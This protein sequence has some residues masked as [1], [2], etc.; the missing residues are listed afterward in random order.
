M[1]IVYSGL[2]NVQCCTSVASVEIK[3]SIDLFLKG[4]S[5]Q[6]NATNDFVHKNVNKLTIVQLSCTSML[7]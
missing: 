1:I 4:E 3:I 6:T 7:C 2:T 5:D